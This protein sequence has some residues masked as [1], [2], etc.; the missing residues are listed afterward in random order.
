MRLATSDLELP[1]EVGLGK[2]LVSGCTCVGKGSVPMRLCPGTVAHIS[3]WL[4]CLAPLDSVTVAPDPHMMSRDFNLTLSILPIQDTGRIRSPTVILE[5]VGD[6]GLS[7]HWLVACALMK[8]A[9]FQSLPTVQTQR[10]IS[11]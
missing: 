8:A 2:F 9:D 4:L 5:E 1:W 3:L 10:R 7:C 6:V 11:H